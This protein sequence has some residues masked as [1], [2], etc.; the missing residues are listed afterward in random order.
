MKNNQ[1]VKDFFKTIKKGFLETTDADYLNQLGVRV[2]PQIVNMHPASDPL[3]QRWESKDREN[4][5]RAAVYT[6]LDSIDFESASN[7]FFPEGQNPVAVSYSTTQRSKVKKHFG[8]QGGITNAAIAAMGG[9]QNTQGMEGRILNAEERTLAT[10]NIAYRNS[11]DNAMIN[12]NET[13]D[14]L[15]FNG[16]EQEVT[17]ANGSLVVDL[18]G[19]DVSKGLL[20]QMVAVQ[21]LIGV[22]VNLILSNPLMINFIKEQYF[23]AIG[24]MSQNTQN[25]PFSFGTI[26]GPN[27]PVEL[28][29]D[30]HVPVTYV[31]GS[32]YTATIY[33]LAEEKDGEDLFYMDYLIPQTILP[34]EVFSDGSHATSTTFGM[35]AVGTLVNRA[36]VA[37]AKISN[38]GFNANAG[39]NSSITSLS[40][41]VI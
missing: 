28:M 33:L 13:T 29:G 14:P 10:L 41:R 2:E 38:A 36:P 27:G 5:D 7:A 26:P 23:P 17:A 22:R 11:L 19:T 25:D 37:Q 16:L 34:N 30:P 4:S 21:A 32:D 40:G 12:G 24:V 3:R 8:V 31:S 39:L 20:D 35:Y 18:S 15:A 9:A 6:T 1:I